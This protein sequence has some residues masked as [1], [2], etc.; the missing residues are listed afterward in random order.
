MN[1]VFDVITSPGTTKSFL[2]PPEI[3]KDSCF[4]IV[5]N[6]MSAAMLLLS[7]TRLL[8]LF[9]LRESR[10]SK[11]PPTNVQYDRIIILIS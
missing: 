5:G 6:L 9:S 3:D 1:P 4:R 7:L 2:A 8:L 11:A 10:G